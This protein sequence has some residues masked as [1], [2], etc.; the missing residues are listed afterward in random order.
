[1]S[2]PE[3]ETELAAELDAVVR[4]VPGVLQT[5]PA[6]PALLAAVTQAASVVL[7]TPLA[8]PV[9]VSRDA[10]GVSVRVTI[11]VSDK[12]PAAETCRA[13]HDAVVGHL[14]ES[15]VRAGRAAASAVDRDVD[16]GADSVARVTVEVAR[17]G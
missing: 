9:G 3:A 14:A 15:A 7:R 16:P 12:R 13:V 4:A 8:P 10:D 6:Q 2:E 1:M 17:I 11:A 5:Y